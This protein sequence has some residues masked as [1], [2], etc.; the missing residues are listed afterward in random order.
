ME[1]SVHH[2]GRLD[3]SDFYFVKSANTGLRLLVTYS[4]S[5]L[6]F[7][8]INGSLIRSGMEMLE[9]TFLSHPWK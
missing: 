6:S 9:E 3:F 8:F 2:C 7:F 5:I 1:A 4:I